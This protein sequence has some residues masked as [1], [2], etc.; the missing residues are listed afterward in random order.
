MHKVKVS[1]AKA[2]EYN[3]G[4]IRNA[5][6]EC[7][8]LLGGLDTIIQP[9]SRVFI[10][11]NHLSSSHSDRG[12]ITHPVFTR[13]VLLL[14]MEHACDIT[15]GDDIH[16]HAAD[17]FSRS[18]YRSM[19]DELGVRLVNLKECGFVEVPVQGRVL[20]SVFLSR[21]VLES[22][23]IIN[24]PKLKTHSF[25]IFTGAVKNMFGVI[26]HGLRLAYHRKFVRNY[27]FSEMLVD[28]FSRVPP[29]L[30][31]ID[32]IVGMEGEGPSAGSPRPLGVII[33]G[34]DAIACDT[35]AAEIVGLRPLDIFTTFNAVQ[36]GLGVGRLAD[37]EIAGKKVEEV[38]VTDFKHSTVAVGLFR[39]RL[40]SFVYAYM[41][42]QLIFIPEVD[43]DACTACLECISI[44]PKKTIHQVREKAWVDAA[45]CIHCLCC[46]E[47]CLSKAIKLKQR[48]VGKIIRKA[49]SLYKKAKSL[50]SK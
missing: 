13:E 16:Q 23:S 36:R 29:H 3:S 27:I 2:P 21:V 48:P 47:I 26:P 42:D 28:I 11:I 19:C 20:K 9:R 24:L 12:I 31:I 4:I 14:L 46:N 6:L 45:A 8:G 50:F 38:R 5:L 18:G 37:I 22:D 44:C 40:P 43:R 39:R 17:G 7:F 10:K 15:V 32:G 1:V 25:T 35:V 30:T 41:Q 34:R 49:S 33:A